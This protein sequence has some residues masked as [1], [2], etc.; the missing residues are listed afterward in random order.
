MLA[1]GTMADQSG[2][3]SQDSFKY[4]VAI[5][6]MTWIWLWFMIPAYLFD[7]HSRFSR[8]YLVEFVADV[9][10]AFMD[11]VAGIAVVAFCNQKSN[12]IAKCQDAAKPKAAAVGVDG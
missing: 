9:F 7:L 5:G 11:M 6:I 4:L 2:Y 10:F 1:F 8:L 12:G 3:T